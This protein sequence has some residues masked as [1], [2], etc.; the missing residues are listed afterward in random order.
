M[1]ESKHSGPEMVPHGTLDF[2]ELA[3]WGYGPTDLVV[4]SSNI[5]PYGPPPS[6]VQAVTKSID[7]HTLA[8]YPD[9][10][11][12]E[13]RQA[14]AAHHDVPPEAI[15]VG[16][17]TADIMWLL[18]AVLL[19]GKSVAVLSPTFGEY[20]NAAQVVDVEVTAISIPGWRLNDDGTFAPDDEQPVSESFATTMRAL[21]TLAPDIVFVCNP[22]SPTG[23]HWTQ[24]E[25]KSM[26]A[27]AP[28]A[29]WIVD[30]AYAA[31][32][33]NPWSATRWSLDRNVVVLHS[34]TKDFSL[35][36]LRL[37]YVVA[38][39][40]IVAELAD[41]QPPW[42]VNTLAQVAGLA[43]MRELAWR[44]ET[45]A[46]LR[47][48]MTRLRDGLARL[49]YATRPTATNYVLAPVPDPRSLRH[50]LLRRRIVVRD[51]TS[52]GLPTFIRLATQR[53]EDN[54]KLLE[55]LAELG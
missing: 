44:K 49:G 48:E 9:R 46:R 28:D 17:G 11:S 37:G 38:R 39:P 13:L 1:P 53:P 34:M 4:F 43:C 35:G 41:S 36:G 14:L 3:E 55:A 16:N 19:R 12:R 20:A 21:A 50:Q 47:E 2:G 25:M 26:M 7:A 10:L 23:E 32:T 8:S 29:L 15:L 31:F 45:M 54:E 27:S 40:S 52:F 24:E 30:E 18:A 6:V 51:C 33:P 42:N 5:N 22:N